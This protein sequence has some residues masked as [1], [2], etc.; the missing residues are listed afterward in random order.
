MR[1]ISDRSPAPGAARSSGSDPPP[2][3]EPSQLKRR[4]SNPPGDDESDE[5]LLPSIPPDAIVPGAASSDEMPIAPAVMAEVM[6]TSAATPAPPPAV[7]AAAP[8]PSVDETDLDADVVTVETK[9]ESPFATK[10][11]EAAAERAGASASAAVP[12]SPATTPQKRSGWGFVVAFVIFATAAGVAL[13][14][15]GGSEEHGVAVVPVQGVNPIAIAIATATA[16]AT[17]TTTTTTTTTASSAPDDVPPG[18]EVPAGYGLIF[19]EAPAGAR[20]RIDGAVVGLGPAT[21]AVAAP[22]YHEVRVE[23]EGHEAK[24]VVEVRAGKTTHA[25][26]TLLP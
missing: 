26:S 18:A 24:N 21:S 19:V 7:A 25:G 20:V 16:T 2:I 6:V 22:G 14:A 10:G 9:Y 11:G 1:E 3:I 8:P 12:S 23:Q 15:A 5:T 4:S 13:R 17:A